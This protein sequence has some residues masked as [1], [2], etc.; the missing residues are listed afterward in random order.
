MEHA[1]EG[2]PTILAY[3]RRIAPKLRAWLL[4][5]DV[6]GRVLAASSPEEALPL[7]SEVD[8]LFGASFPPELIASA[9][10]LQWIQSMNAGI[11]E[12]VVADTIP[13]SVIVTRVVGQFGKAIAE[14]VFAELLAHVRELDRTRAA[15]QEQRWEHFIA[16]T[17][18]GQTLGVAGLGSIGGEI[19]R[20]GRAF[21]MT[22][23]GLSRTGAA[24]ELVDRHFGPD[25]WLDFAGSVDVLV[26]TLPRT[27][28]TESVVGRA[29]LGAMRPHAVLVNVGRGALIDEDALISA[30]QEGRIGRA[31]LDVFVQEP[32][33]AESPLWST[34]NVV[35]TPHVSG[36]STVDGVGQYFL[37]NLERYVA[38]E[39]LV[40]IVD[41]AKGY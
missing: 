4:D 40:G 3:S 1:R 11:E 37:A 33:P 14:Y 30:A 28:E 13:E 15:Q 38:G 12:L 27:T 6:Q 5:H 41:R 18:E 35:V 25:D 2:G 36:P 20:K 22:V 10:R 16:G 9:P 19:V 8:I 31:I 29:V 7:I 23:H 21:D 32:L 39:A 26:L 24:A 17:L 34:P